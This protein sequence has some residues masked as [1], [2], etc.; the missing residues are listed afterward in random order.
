MN[1]YACS[2]ASKNFLKQQKLQ[3]I[4][5]LN[6]GFNESEILQFS[7]QD[8]DEDFFKI[9]P[10]ANERNRVGFYS[11][12]PYIILKAMSKIPEGAVLLYL[13]VNDSP[14]QGIQNYIINLFLENKSINIVAPETNYRNIKYCSWYHKRVSKFFMQIAFRI[15]FQPE[16]GVL[17]IRNTQEVK[18]LIHTWLSLTVSHAYALKEKNDI[19]SRHDQET[20]FILSQLNRTI[21]LQSWFVFK[22]FG[23]GIR[24]YIDFE[25]FRG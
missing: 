7:E 3:Y 1:I 22:I 13:D 12:K 4:Q 19:N 5:F 18:N 25:S 15:F 16:A 23:K 9:I 17:L 24:K 14:L 8:L 11:F 2:F 21:R 6:I 10:W 20:L